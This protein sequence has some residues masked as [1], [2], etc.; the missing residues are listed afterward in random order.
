[1]SEVSEVDAAKDA[2]SKVD[3]I[4]TLVLI[5]IVIVSTVFWL[6]NQ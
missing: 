1:M 4:A 3:A 5:T 6:T 2:D